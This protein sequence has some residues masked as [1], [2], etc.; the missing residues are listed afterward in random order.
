[1]PNNLNLSGDMIASSLGKI[2]KG[3]CKDYTTHDFNRS[4]LTS[5]AINVANI[6]ALCSHQSGLKN[7]VF[8]SSVL[9]SD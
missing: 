8:S 4:L 5:F 7:I 6:S 1:M 2:G 3:T 9:N